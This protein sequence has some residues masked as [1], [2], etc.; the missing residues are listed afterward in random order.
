M[1]T[2]QILCQKQAW[3]LNQA[4]PRLY[5]KFEAPG[6]RSRTKFDVLGDAKWLPRYGGL[7]FVSTCANG[8]RENDRLRTKENHADCRA[9]V[10][11]FGGEHHPGTARAVDAMVEKLEGPHEHGPVH[12]NLFLVSQ[13]DEKPSQPLLGHNPE[14]ETKAKCQTVD[15]A[16][17]APRMTHVEVQEDVV[18]LEFTNPRHPLYQMLHALKSWSEIGLLPPRLQNGS[19]PETGDAHDGGAACADDEVE[20]RS[21]TVGQGPDKSR[22]GESRGSE[23]GHLGSFLKEGEFAPNLE[24]LEY[25]EAVRD[26]SNLLIKD[27]FNFCA[28][29][30]G[31]TV[32]LDR[33]RFL[34]RL[35]KYQQRKR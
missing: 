1:P 8:K 15:E 34:A 20:R 22:N 26:D 4:V 28:S 3:I 11:V 6:Q 27:T 10:C 2:L 31:A 24:S 19:A 21:S 13:N 14:D 7:K 23:E 5:V 17:H 16:L 18:R 29:G 32:V 30:A 33:D 25:A 9:L 12:T 35:K